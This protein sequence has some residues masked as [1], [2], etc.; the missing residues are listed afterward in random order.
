MGASRLGRGRASP[1]A[2]ALA[3][4][5]EAT[6]STAP[7]EVALTMFAFFAEDAGA[8]PPEGLSTAEGWAACW[9]TVR[10]VWPGAPDLFGLL[11][12]LPPHLA[13]GARTQADAVV[14]GPQLAGADLLAGVRMAREND[15]A[16]AGI[17]A[18]V[19][20]ALGPRGRCGACGADAP[21]LHLMRTRG[22]D[23]RHGLVCPVCAAVLRSYWRFGEAE[24]LEA[25]AP[26]A[27]AL[28]LVAEATVELAGTVLGFQMLPA[29]RRAL[30]AGALCARFTQL[31]LEPYEVELPGDAVGVAA[32]PTVLAPGASIARG[33]VRFVVGEDARI[34]D[35]ELL[36]VLRVRIERRFRP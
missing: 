1:A 36:D 15:A 31:Y 24:G 34:T 29:E 14:A 13:L 7:W 23:E 35:E 26:H 17:A 28:G 18:Q 32:G 19:L 27:L 6:A 9:E 8:R 10:A 22:L 33:G 21:A 20:A 4:T 16:V 25:L 30:T 2:R 3:G 5:L 11:A 12:R